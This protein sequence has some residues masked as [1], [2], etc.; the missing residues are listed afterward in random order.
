M[1]LFGTGLF[2]S[3]YANVDPSWQSLA[4]GLAYKKLGSFLTFPTGVLHAFQIDLKNYDFDITPVEKNIYDTMRQHNASIAINGGFFTPEMKPLGLRISQGNQFNPIKST[5]WWSI[6]FIKNNKAHITPQANYTPSSDVRFAVQAGPRLVVNGV[7]P[8]K[9]KSGADYRT[10]L[11]IQPSGKVIL[12]VTESLL[13]ST[14]EL[15]E[16]MRRPE[17]EGGLNCV[18][19]LNL[20]GGSSTQLYTQIKNFSLSLNGISQVADTILVIPKEQKL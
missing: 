14:Q 10:A 7:V 20:D 17:H 4:P 19:A 5:S 18:D 1:L 11:G 16:I 6:F 15:A 13:L 12:L 8:P 3:A 2:P 9:L